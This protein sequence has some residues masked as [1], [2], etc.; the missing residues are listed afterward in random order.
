[1]PKPSTNRAYE[2]KVRDH[3]LDNGFVMVVRAASSGQ[4]TPDLVGITVKGAAVLI[5]VK[6]IRHYTYR[7][8]NTTADKEQ[9]NRYRELAHNNGIVIFYAVCF[10]GV[11]KIPTS[12]FI[13]RP[14]YAG[15]KYPAMSI[16]P[17]KTKWCEIYIAK[18]GKLRLYHPK[19]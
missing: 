18:D 2:W 12:M 16:Y 3:L 9:F 4:H 8:T 19:G 17:Q 14:D 6:S 1:M 15:P 11:G 5:E 10:K 7:P 13:F